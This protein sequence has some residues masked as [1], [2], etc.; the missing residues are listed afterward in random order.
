MKSR[1]RGIMP[2]LLGVALVGGACGSSR[3]GSN[4]SASTAGGSGTTAAAASASK[5]TGSPLTFGAIADLTGTAS[6]PQPTQGIEA[7]ANFVNSHGGIDGH[8]LV[9]ES[10]DGAESPSQTAACGQRFASNPSILGAFDLGGDQFGQSDPVLAA[11]G[12]GIVDSNPVLSNEFDTPNGIAATGGVPTSLGALVKYFVT[13]KHIKTIAFTSLDGVGSQIQAVLESFTKPAGVTVLPFLF[14]E[15]TTDYTAT[16]TAIA[17]SKADLIIGATGVQS[18]GSLLVALKAA[19]NTIPV[20]FFDTSITPAGIKQ[21][22]S[23]A[24][25]LYTTS[26]FPTPAIATGADLTEL[27][28]YAAGMKAAGQPESTGALQ[29]WA[30]G[31]LMTT[32]VKQIGVANVTRAAILNVIKTGTIT[33]AP[34]F[35]SPMGKKVSAPPIAAFGSLVNPE[36][37][38]GQYQNGVFN[39]VPGSTRVNPYTP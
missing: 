26:A 27:N 33:D 32:I 17:S 35:P 2:V 8:R 28:D 21:A 29:G 19:G 11:A 39:I 38:I 24:N 4:S 15:T 7:Y 6:S 12:V 1:V 22:G 34:L 3:S 13:T 18:V 25:G 30:S 37:F 5:A 10:C 23:A 36:E 14:P 9:I 31:V 16:A 20:S